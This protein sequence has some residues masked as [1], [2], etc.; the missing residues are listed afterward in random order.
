MA[1]LMGLASIDIPQMRTLVTDLVN[2]R[3]HVE[4]N[5]KAIANQLLTVQV[6]GE[7]LLR[8][9]TVEGW[10]DEQVPGIRRRLA[11]AEGIEAQSPGAGTVIQIDEAL[12][13]TAT[14]AEARADARRA[15]E[16]I[17][18]YGTGQLQYDDLAASALPAELLTLLAENSLDPYFADELARS[19]NAEAVAA[20][21]KTTS[22][23]RVHVFESSQTD[24]TVSEVDEQ[25]DALLWGLGESLGLATR[26]TGELALPSSWGRDWVA[27][28]TDLPQSDLALAASRTAALSLV[29]SRGTW[30]PDLVMDTADALYGVELAYGP[31]AW[32]G[33]TMAAIVAPGGYVYTDPLAGV[34]AAASIYP[35]VTQ[36]L[37]DDSHVTSVTID[38]QVISLT[39]FLEYSLRRDWPSDKGAAL[40]AALSSATTPY[41]GG[42]TISNVIAADA[43][44]VYET[45]TAEYE[46]ATAEAKAD[47]HGW[48]STLGHLL[49]DVLGFIPFLG[50]PAD[51]ANAA[52][53]TAEGNYTDA[54]LSSAGMVVGVGWAAV[55]GKW[56]RRANSAEELLEIERRF[57]NLAVDAVGAETTAARV[58]T[59]RP[60]GG[61]FASPARQ[62]IQ[63][64]NGLT[65]VTRFAPRQM[66]SLR[67]SQTTIAELLNDPALFARRGEAQW[68][69]EEL[70]TLAQTDVSALTAGQ[71]GVLTD[72]AD[73][74]PPPRIGDA[75]QKVLTPTQVQYILNPAHAGDRL[76]GLD[77]SGSVTRLEDAASLGSPATLHGALRLDYVRSPFSPRDSSVYVMR[78][79]L[80]AD[81]DVSRFSQMGGRSGTGGTD[82]WSPPYTGNGF[83]KSDDLIPEYRTSASIATEGAE[84]WE[85]LQD[86]TQV[87]AAV[88]DSTGWVSVS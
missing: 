32:A 53:Y 69:R 2:A 46:A 5:R 76:K 17:A 19:T 38:G 68:T 10:L 52:W 73:A 33:L 63:L 11:L 74:L 30:S 51:G 22:E 75:V 65:H 66:S 28:M 60:T 72:I 57:G 70:Q 18:A 80:N 29:M 36:E 13:S 39:G 31:D 81:A 77:I 35:E 23:F 71:K 7:P 62:F 3:Y 78:A 14:V 59:G 25:Y 79:R 21:V 8:L 27:T 12:V 61:V 15:A 4:V 58:A 6:S 84:V 88:R 48:F 42:S 40:S 56:V 64:A 49:L 85:I 43:A 86:G 83:L 34:L 9:F 44:A 87:L 37:F 55:G 82:G 41:V 20:L 1:F 45:M 54:A 16:L 24:L 26:G 47:D 67:N 50:E